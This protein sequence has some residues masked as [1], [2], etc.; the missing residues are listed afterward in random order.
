[1]PSFVSSALLSTIAV[2]MKRNWLQ[3]TPGDRAAMVSHITQLASSPGA[4]SSV[5]GIKLLLAFV[6]EMRGSSEKKTRAMLQPMAFHTSCRTT[7]E[8]DGLVQI[9]ALAVHLITN[10]P[11]SQALEHVYLLMV[12]LL[13]WFETTDSTSILLAVDARW[14]PYLVQASFI[15]AVF[16][17]YTTHRSHNLGSHTIRQVLILL[18]TV[19]GLLHLATQVN[20]TITIGP[21]F[22]TPSDQI[23]YI[24][25]IFHGA[26]FIFHHPLPSNVELE[27]VDMCQLTYRLVSNWGSLN[28]P[29]MAEPLVSEVA[30][31]SCLLLQSALQDTTDD[32]DDAALWQMEGLDVL[33]DAWSILTANASKVSAV[34]AGL[35]A[36]SAQ[37][38][39]LYLQVR[40]RL[41][42]RS[43]ENDVDED[44]EIEEN[45]AK[46]LEEQ[47][48]LV[49]A[50]ARL[51]APHN[52]SLCLHLLTSHQRMSHPTKS[53]D[54]VSYRHVLDKLHFLVLFTGIV[55][56]DDYRGEKPSIP[57]A[58]E[59]AVLP[60]V[61]QVIHVVLRLLGDEV[62]AVEAAPHLQSPYFSEQLV[63]TTTRLHV[64][65]FERFPSKADMVELFCKC[66]HVPSQ[67]RGLV[68]EAVVRIVVVESPEKLTP[69]V[70][71]WHQALVSLT[72][73]GASNDVR[74]H[75]QVEITF[76]S[77]ASIVPLVLKCACDF[78]EANLA[79]LT[80]TKAIVLYNHCDRLI[81][82][83]CASHSS[84]TQRATTEEE[85]FEDILMLLTLLSHLVAKDVIDF[86][87]DSANS[88]GVV[89]DVVFSGLNQVIPLMT[90]DLLQYPKLSVQYFTLVSYLHNNTDIVR[91]SFQSVGE[92]AACQLR[93]E[94]SAPGLLGQF[95]PIV[96]QM[97]VFESSSA[98][99]VDGAAIALY[100][101][102]LVERTNV[103]AIAQAFCTGMD[104]ALHDTMMQALSQLT[105]SLP[106]SH[107]T[108]VR[109]GEEADDK[110]EEELRDASMLPNH[111]PG[112]R[113]RDIPRSTKLTDVETL[114]F[115][116][117]F[118]RAGD[119]TDN[120]VIDRCNFL[121]RHAPPNSYRKLKIKSKFIQ[122]IKR[123]EKV[124]LQEH[125]L[126]RDDCL[127]PSGV[128]WKTGEEIEA[129]GRDCFPDDVMLCT[130]DKDLFKLW[131]L[132]SFMQGIGTLHQV[133]GR[134]IDL[135]RKIMHLLDEL[136]KQY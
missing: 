61:E 96:L 8:K 132:L 136:G 127:Q 123:L 37:V 72:Q 28:D 23:A 80:L 65:Y 6:T 104:T 47:L 115:F 29:A 22:E 88:A 118:K 56:A 57:A 103:F 59:G 100:Y 17:T 9:L 1:M 21:I 78:V 16:E 33:M 48:G 117:E 70:T 73:S 67:S 107:S 44:D 113:W 84:Q 53:L 50:L 19:T 31:L 2:L 5:L 121:M 119:L 124:D 126:S 10:Q 3:E 111:I 133:D 94:P 54:D 129:A 92:L 109:S 114:T 125:C 60:L 39:Q 68:C 38:V 122:L 98:V 45:V 27:V 36:A 116:S 83:F 71:E 12:E 120:D 4:S 51:N 55:L 76:H 20:V 34:S 13:Q 134:A 108:S 91:Y 79:Y 40:L 77:V 90:H 52:L 112:R 128:V 130:I 63:S 26:L 110:E 131:P 85:Q 135:G 74:V 62:K 99:V 35:Q 89:A 81:G 25:W 106:P 95:I 14:R 58:M 93:H 30:K 86:A 11:S 41:V 49:A 105:Q 97:L 24:T 42:C 75:Q 82:T 102:L 69:F 18:A 32:V 43:D 87:D 15:Q 66:A 64:T 101:L 46:T 7:L